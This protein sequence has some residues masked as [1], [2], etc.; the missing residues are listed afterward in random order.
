MDDDTLASLRV[1]LAASPNNVELLVLVASALVDRDRAEEAAELVR[2]AGLDSFSRSGHRRAAARALF[3]AGDADAALGLIAPGSE[4][5]EEAETLLLRARILH[6]LGR[7]KDAVKAYQAAV[8]ANPTLEDLDLKAMLGA[9]VREI[10]SGGDRP[11][12]RVI[13][14]ANDDTDATELTRLLHP[15]TKTV[16]FDD[17]GGLTDVKKQIERRIIVPF[18]KPSLFQ[19]FK[20]RVG[21]GILLYGPPGC[22]KTLLA[23]ATAGECKATFFNVA[24]HDILDMYIGESE[25]KLHAIFDKARASTPAVLFFDELEA[26]AGKRQ[27]TREATSAKLVSQFLSEMDG[28]TQNNAGVLILGATNVPWAVDAAFRRPGRFDRVLFVPPP[29]KVARAAILRHLLEARP[30]E[31]IDADAIA[32]KTSGFS[33]ADLE[34]LIETA[35]DEAIEAS[36]ASGSEVPIAQRHLVAAL[37]DVKPTT[38]EWLTTARNYA[39]YANEGGQ[40]DDVLD[41]LKRHGK[42]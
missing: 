37:R 20:K 18:Q 9:R 19:R 29:D 11:K 35:S 10:P 41:F 6:Q 26:L 24:I 28:F 2:D 22:G 16:T 15:E 30:T 8:E 34:H 14:S 33:G 7:P 36:L 32:S 38:L 12:M 25:R 42:D 40:Y 4:S 17:V 21:G 31:D 39:R 3:E 13:S 23:R 1:A 27:H 5:K